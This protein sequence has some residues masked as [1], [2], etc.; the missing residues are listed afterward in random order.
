M[1]TLNQT[2]QMLGLLQENQTI[3]EL[4][5][6]LFFVRIWVRITPDHVLFYTWNTKNCACRRPIVGQHSTSWFWAK[7]KRDRQQNKSID[8]T[9]PSLTS[10]CVKYLWTSLYSDGHGGLGLHQRQTDGHRGG[11]RLDSRCR[12]LNRH[13]LLLAQHCR[14]KARVG[15]Y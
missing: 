13:H 1:N 5:K 12:N 14:S 11:Q 7:Y 15:S 9:I 3:P 10:G 2:T 6:V 4:V 8:S